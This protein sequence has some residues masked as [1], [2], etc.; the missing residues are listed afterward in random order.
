MKS[1]LPCMASRT[2]F[3]RQ[4]MRLWMRPERELN[5]TEQQITLPTPVASVEQTNDEN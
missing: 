4:D 1:T 2:P 3:W 5:V